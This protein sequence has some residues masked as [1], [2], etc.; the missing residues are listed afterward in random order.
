MGR[1]RGDGSGGNTSN[2]EPWGAMGSHGGRWGAAEE[3]SLAHPPLTSCCAARFLTGRGPVPVCALGGGGLGT[4]A[5]TS[6]GG[7]N[8]ELCPCLDE[9]QRL[10]DNS[11]SPA[12]PCWLPGILPQQ[13]WALHGLRVFRGPLLEHK[14]SWEGVEISKNISAAGALCHRPNPCGEEMEAHRG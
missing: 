3:A 2:G 4:P 11:M 8:R 14:C 7:E 13:Y 6:R 10:G 9:S 12:L 5:L 1:R